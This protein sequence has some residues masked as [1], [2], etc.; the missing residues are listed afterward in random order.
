[1]YD[2]LAISHSGAVRIVIEGL[3]GEQLSHSVERE[4][5]DRDGKV[6]RLAVPYTSKTIIE[7]TLSSDSD[8]NDTVI[9]TSAGRFR[10][11]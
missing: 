3:V 6:G 10:A 7:F 1:M 2:V 4:E 11:L 9:T 5:P 8:G